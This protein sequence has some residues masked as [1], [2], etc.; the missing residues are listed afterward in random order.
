MT[1]LMKNIHPTMGT[2]AL[3]VYIPQK[4]LN[5]LYGKTDEATSW[6]GV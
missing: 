1:V 4:E 3:F 5:I 2:A 6:C